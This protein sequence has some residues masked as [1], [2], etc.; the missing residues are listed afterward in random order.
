MVTRT[1]LRRPAPGD[2]AAPAHRWALLGVVCLGLMVLVVDT[3]IVN[4]ALPSLGRQLGASTS[5][6][7]WIV[8][9]YIVVYAGLLLTAGSLGDRFGRYRAFTLGLAVFGVGSL[10][11]ALADSV[12]VLIAMRA[13][14]G[15][16]A[17]LVMPTTLS[18]ISNVFT[19]P[20]ERA[21]AIGI[22]AG[23]AGLGAAVGPLAGGFL[24]THF[25]W[26]SVFAVN[27][28]IA[29][30]TIV[31]A[32]LLIPES[33]DPVARRQ[34]PVG[35]VLSIAGTGVALWGIIQAPEH[36]WASATTIATLGAGLALA[37]AFVAWELRCPHPMLDMR[38]FRRPRFTVASL[39]ITCTFFTLFGSMFVLTQYLQLVLGFGT[40]RAGVTVLPLALAMVVVSPQAGALARR[41][42]DK[43]VVA[44]GAGIVAVAMAL[45]AWLGADAPLWQPMVA[46]GINGLGM[47]LAFGPATASLMGAVPRE[48]A[49]VG[50]AMNDTTRQFGGALGVAVFGSVLASRYHDAA[51]RAA[52][53]RGLPA[54]ITDAVT[55]DVS[56]ALRFARSDG[57]GEWAAAA[58]AAAREGF[59]D[60]FH[61]VALV[62]AVVMAVGAA[63]VLAWL[64][65]RAEAAD[66][67]DP[68]GGPGPGG[69]G[70][71]GEPSGLRPPAAAAARTAGTT[72]GR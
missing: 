31:G 44:T 55:G 42:G 40:L 54:S 57:A 41:Y 7:Q 65:A 32:Y 61:T 43:A 71:A 36:G 38:F 70:P 35:A 28:P 14:M 26:G 24:L 11:A 22:W 51:E 27:L 5:E 50:S 48:R 29:A 4:V 9:A 17:A 8:D 46:S 72:A 39:V 20:G 63:V 53:A 68:D 56:S 60:S 18:I 3:T 30:A 10:G 59:V 21:R 13:F 67:T 2:G 34:D 15:V 37:V 66:A 19:D 49:G 33:R 45:L 16:G 69:C 1:Q 23:V 62:G 6:L 47:G 25:Y 52:A 64:P 12:A 58:A